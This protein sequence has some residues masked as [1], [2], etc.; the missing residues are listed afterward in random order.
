MCS[1]CQAT[2]GRKKLAEG[3]TEIWFLLFWPVACCTTA[4]GWSHRSRHLIGSNWFQAKVLITT[5][6]HSY[7]HHCEFGNYTQAK[8][9]P[10]SF[11]VKEEKIII[12]HLPSTINN[13]FT[14]SL[15]NYVHCCVS[16]KKA[17]LFPVKRPLFFLLISPP[18]LHSVSTSR[19]IFC[20][21]NADISVAKK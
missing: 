21:S 10:A 5:Y 17:I 1:Q 7:I 11:V 15:C 20:Q 14:A 16:L 19:L 18:P 2:H 6:K 8:G 3:G 9:P 4:R 13:P 12:I